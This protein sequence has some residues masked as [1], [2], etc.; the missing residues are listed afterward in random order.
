MP[1]LAKE[2][3]KIKSDGLWRKLR[4]YCPTGPVTGEIDGQ[5]VINFA[6]NDYL[7]L[8]H[9]SRVRAAAQEALERY[10]SGGGASRLLSG[11]NILYQK[12]EQR[13]AALKRTEAAL[14][15]PTGYQANLGVLTSLAGRGDVIFA[16]KFNHASLIDGCLLSGAAVKRYPHKDLRILERW[17]SAAASFR[18]RLIVTDAVFS[19]DGDLAPLPALAELAKRYDA[20]IVVD[21]AHGTGVLGASGGGAVDFLNVKGISVQIGTLSKALGSLGGFVAGNRGLIDYLINKARPLIFTT[22]LPPAT[23]AAAMTALEVIKDEPQWRS[24][25]MNNAVYLRSIL[26]TT[27]INVDDQPTPIIPVTAGSPDTALKLSLALFDNGFLIPAIRPPAVPA[28][29]S[30]LRI[31]VSAHHTREQMDRL[32][33]ALRRVMGN[34]GRAMSSDGKSWTGMET[35]NR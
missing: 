22:A 1:D 31:T 13:L 18:R 20:L 33:K 35:G 11:N 34:G 16:D 23:L 27:G 15:F 10:G 4:A 28:G 5:A 30:R 19:M 9:H 24:K 3:R 32:V 17:M 14:V 8:S 12:L 29:S 25:L 6:A 7:G 2:L 21:D 26:K